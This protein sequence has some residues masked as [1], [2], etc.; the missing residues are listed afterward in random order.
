M[1]EQM[2][3]K[4][5]NILLVGVLLVLQYQVFF[6]DTGYLKYRSIL[7]DLFKQ[8]EVNQHLQEQNESLYAEV[9][10]LRKGMSAIE[11]RARSD[12]GFIKKNEQYYQLIP[13]Q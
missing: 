12:L 5:L 6:S 1:S 13:D 9:E 3:L 11:E 7:A 4:V 2:D 8:V 10:N